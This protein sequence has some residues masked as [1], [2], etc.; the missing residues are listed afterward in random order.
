MAILS[1]DIQTKY[2]K[3]FDRTAD[4]DRKICVPMIDG[5]A[6]PYSFSH[7]TF[8]TDAD[9]KTDAK[10]TLSLDGVAWDSEV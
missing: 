4:V 5:V 1:W 3:N 8:E 7:A 6:L 9:I 2:V 10:S